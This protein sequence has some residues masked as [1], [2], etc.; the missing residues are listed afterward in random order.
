MS[1]WVDL[2]RAAAALNVALLATVSGIW[3][4]NFGRFRS[5]HTF[6]LAAFGVLLLAENVVTMYVFAIHP[7]LSPWVASVSPIAQQALAAVKLL[8][9]GALGVLTW[10]TWD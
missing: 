1:L 7:Q 10:T 3:L 9:S 2:L 8:E 4:R 6:G 5:K